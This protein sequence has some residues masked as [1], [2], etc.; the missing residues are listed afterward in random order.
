MK[1]DKKQ[2]DTMTVTLKQGQRQT[3]EKLKVMRDVMIDEARKER[4]ST[5]N[6]NK[7]RKRKR[8]YGKQRSE[9]TQEKNKK[10]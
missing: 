6:P 8:Y 10:T 7:K 9:K 4:A 5:N 2:D 1:K 3:W